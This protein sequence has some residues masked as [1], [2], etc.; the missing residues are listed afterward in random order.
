MP[1]LPRH[2]HFVGFGLIASSLARALRVF[3]PSLHLTVYDHDPAVRQTVHDLEL[4]DQ[5]VDTL[6]AVPEDTDLVMIAVPMLAFS[7]VLRNLNVPPHAIITD[8]G[9]VKGT[10][11]EALRTH[12]PNLLSRFVLGH[13]LAGTEHSGPEHGFATLFQ[14]RWCLLTP[15]PETNPEAVAT[16]KHLWEAVGA[17]VNTMSVAHHDQIL[18]ITSHIPHLIAFTIVDTAMTLEDD[19]RQEV[20]QYAASGFRD[21]T[22]IA[23]SD[24]TMW[25]DIFLTNREAVLSMLDR[26]TEDLDVLKSAIREGNGDLLFKKFTDARAI[27]RDI[28]AAGQA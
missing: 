15:L 17:R 13:P 1:V 8:V 25:R 6:S 12:A 3:D 14:N 10:V 11:A 19:L 24:P 9:S 20:I 28:I 21:F 16:V 2:L 26:F 5:V 23:A 4:A 18:A 22:R 7:E 27:R